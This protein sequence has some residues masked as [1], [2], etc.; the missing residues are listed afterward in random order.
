MGAVNTPVHGLYPSPMFVKTV[1][2]IIVRW[3]TS[4]V[5]LPMEVTEKNT[6]NL[7]LGAVAHGVVVGV[8]VLIVDVLCT[9]PK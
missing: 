1:L 3:S 6:G 5:A 4:R 2:K 9:G 7:R 8:V